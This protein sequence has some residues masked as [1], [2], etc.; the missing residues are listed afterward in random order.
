[1]QYNHT[2]TGHLIIFVL[3]GVAG[4]FGFIANKI[5]FEPR[6]FIVLILILLLGL[7]FTTLNVTVDTEYLRIKFGPGIFKKKFALKEII[8]VKAAKH[9]WYHGW[10]IKFCLWPR[11]WI[12]NVSGFDVI[13]IK[14]ANGK[15][16]RIGT[17]ESENLKQAI[18]QSTSLKNF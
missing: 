12:F 3:L 10:G 6:L 18:E 9:R 17:D 16:F 15:I 1:M 13:E 7:S 5:G 14:M 8:S 2:Q 4:Y 11:M